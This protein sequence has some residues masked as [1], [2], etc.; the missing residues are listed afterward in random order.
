MAA[1]K[2]YPF[3][4]SKQPSPH[5]QPTMDPK[6]QTAVTY[7]RTKVLTS[8]ERELHD[9]AAVELKKK[10]VAADGSTDTDGDSG[11]YFPDRCHAFKRWLASVGG[12]EAAVK[13]SGR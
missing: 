3:S 5:P 6:T 2:V 8:Q 10:F 13:L 7:W 12:L 4:Q 1:P 9:L 11:S